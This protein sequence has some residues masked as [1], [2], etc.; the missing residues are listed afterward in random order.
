MLSV[1]LLVTFFSFNST[2][3]IVHAEENDFEYVERD[4]LEIGEPN[5]SKYA[6]GNEKF[7]YRLEARMPEEDELPWYRFVGRSANAINVAISET[8]MTINRIVFWFNVKLSGLVIGTLEAT[9]N[10]KFIDRVIDD[11]S[12]K[13]REFVGVSG[14]I[15]PRFSNNG[16]FLPILKI[17]ALIVV[18]Y[19]FYQ[20]IWKRSFVSSFGELLKYITVLTISLLL[21]TNFSSFL[22]GM[23]N[24][25][26]GIGNLISGSSSQT[27]TF[28]ESL[29]D[30]FVD[31]T[32]LSLQYGT[33]DVRS[34]SA[35][36]VDGRTRVKELLK[37]RTGSSL[38]EQIIDKE[39]NERNNYYMTYDSVGDKTALNM[40]LLLLNGLTSIPVFMISFAILFTQV[41]FVIIAMIAPFALLI[42]S[43]PSQ[44]SVVKRY[45]FELSLPLI[46]KIALHFVLVIII[47]LTNIASG[48]VADFSSDLF[49]GQIGNAFINSIFYLMLFV[50]IF[51]LRNRIMNILSSGS[52][53]VS[54]IREG[55]GSVTTKPVKQAVQTG[56]TVAGAT[57]GAMVGGVQGAMVGASM[58]STVGNL[59]TGGTDLA[60]A[61]QDVART[62]YQ[63]QMLSHLKERST[64]NVH[65]NF[66]TQNTKLTPEQERAEEIRKEKDAKLMEQG[67]SDMYEIMEEYGV[68]EAEKESFVKELETHGVDMRKV[69]K[70]TFERHINNG[71]SF[72]DPKSFAENIRK[73]QVK[74]KIKVNKIKD[75]RRKEFDSFL[76]E[77]NLTSYEKEDIYTHLDQKAID[78]SLIPK[79]IYKQIDKDI[80][81]RLEEGEPLDYV[82]EF[83][84]RL[85]EWNE[86][87]ILEE[88]RERINK[89]MPRGNL[90]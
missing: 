15:T 6:E 79:Y 9:M 19:A 86:E 61:T 73:E 2:S 12:Q 63:G 74:Q 36:G 68:T 46:I 85:E 67:Y 83:K 64:K 41:W 80:R 21:F 22:T 27:E 82:R 78:A 33:T 18:F 25:S 8:V 14:N 84:T 57:A 29:W 90:N 76:D 53:M 42:A 28:S 11:I 17:T 59:A 55:L 77:Q 71:E 30:H 72:A 26:N 70:A 66:E 23:N 32:Y 56:T 31:K 52:E 39:V 69:N 37:A 49:G 60:G 65:Q 5:R 4:N 10:F 24:V 54:Q 7:Y 44:F 45:F 43:F 20:L 50:G 3:N 38:R 81:A 34:L 58:G 88:Q 13:T 47:F 51:L 48:A 75:R 35:E 16:M 62:A 89:E 87:K 40:G 1:L